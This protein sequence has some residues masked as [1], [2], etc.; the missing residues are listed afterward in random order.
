M[1]GGGR[2]AVLK[3]ITIIGY[4][5]RPPWPVDMYRKSLRGWKSAVCTTWAKILIHVDLIQ[6]WLPY[7]TSACTLWSIARALFQLSW[8][9]RDAPVVHVILPA[10]TAL[11]LW[12]KRHTLVRGC[13]GRVYS[14]KKLHHPA[15]NDS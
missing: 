7:P 5:L 6:T 13:S 15:C 2:I 9:S 8:Y 14:I 3:R 4:G 12:S 1:H 10:R 11:D